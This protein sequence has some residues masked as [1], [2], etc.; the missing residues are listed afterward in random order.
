MKFI[1]SCIGRQ[2]SGPELDLLTLY[3]NRL[4]VPLDIKEFETKP[5]L[6]LEKR[7][8]LEA[9][10]LLSPFSGTDFIVALDERGQSLSSQDLA[11]T[12]DR[13][14]VESFK[15]M[16]FIIGGAD[17]LDKS[18]RQRANITLSLGSMTWPHM[19]VRPLIVEQIYRALCILSNHPYH[20]N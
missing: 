2:K 17:G 9:E 14:Q 20:R 16:G 1:L 6:P 3:K 12:I 19:L 10:L 13:A 18:V 7:K 5:A 15:S 11:K 8:A 4:T